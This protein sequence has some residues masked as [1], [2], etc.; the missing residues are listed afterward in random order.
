MLSRRQEREQIRKSLGFR[1]WSVAFTIF[2]P[3]ISL[4]TWIF[5]GIVLLFSG[6]S[7]GLVWVLK[8]GRSI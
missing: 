7:R 2:Y 1:I 4:F 5:T 8:G 3:F 6:L